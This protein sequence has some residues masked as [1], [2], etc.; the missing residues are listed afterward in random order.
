MC[1]LDHAVCLAVSQPLSDPCSP[2]RLSVQLVDISEVLLSSEI[3][4]LQSAVSQP[5]GSIQAL[6]VPRGAVRK[7]TFPV[8]EYMDQYDEKS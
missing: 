1:V 2:S 7:E 6:N 8:V 5:G 3:E 4:F